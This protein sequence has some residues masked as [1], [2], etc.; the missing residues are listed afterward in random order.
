[1]S[2]LLLGLALFFAAHS[3]SIVNDPS[4]A[5]WLVCVPLNMR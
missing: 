1:M 2:A 3:V 4:L 5:A